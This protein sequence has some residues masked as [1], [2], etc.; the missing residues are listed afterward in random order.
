MHIERHRNRGCRKQSNRH[1]WAGLAAPAGLPRLV[2]IVL[3]AIRGDWRIVC[4]ALPPDCHRLPKPA[5]TCHGLSVRNE[6]F[7]EA[8]IG[9]NAAR[10]MIV[11][12]DVSAGLQVKAGR[13]RA[14]Y[15]HASLGKTVDRGRN[16]GQGPVG[17][18][19]VCHSGELNAARISGSLS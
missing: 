4:Q 8:L 19:T 10:S 1:L 2:S 12:Q 3:Q 9:P 11:G 13:V 15:G 16:A 5:M 14:T 18:V 7:A 6:V 17:P